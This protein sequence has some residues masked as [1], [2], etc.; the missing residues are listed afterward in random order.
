MLALTLMSPV[1]TVLNLREM[2]DIASI[3]EYIEVY[4][5]SN[6]CTYTHYAMW[7]DDW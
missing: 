2:Y 5:V 1:D 3:V 4:I 7:C 6:A